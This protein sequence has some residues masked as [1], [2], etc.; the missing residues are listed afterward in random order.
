MLLRTLTDEDAVLVDVSTNEGVGW[1]MIST[2]PAA[3]Y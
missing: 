2:S 1:D 3:L